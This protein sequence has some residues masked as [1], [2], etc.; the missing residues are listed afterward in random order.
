MSVSGRV[1]REEVDGVVKGLVLL[2]D[3]VMMATL[4]AGL[5]VLGLEAQ[6][7]SLDAHT[8]E[9]I[10]GGV[11][12]LPPGTRLNLELLDQRRFASGFLYLRYAIT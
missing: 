4:V 9:E 10:L 6:V 2:T 5:R 11:H 1:G 8:L 12:R 3:M 7:L